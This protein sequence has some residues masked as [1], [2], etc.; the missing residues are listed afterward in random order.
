MTCARKEL[1][2]ALLFFLLCFEPHFNYFNSLVRTS[3]TSS[4]CIF[5]FHALNCN[6]IDKVLM[7]IS[8]FMFVWVYIMLVAQINQ[9][10]VAACK[11][12]VF[13]LRRAR[14]RL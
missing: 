9:L 3:D 10:H 13:V 7:D 12:S 6:N 5:T 2:F 1:C 8:H 11:L 14:S 4:S